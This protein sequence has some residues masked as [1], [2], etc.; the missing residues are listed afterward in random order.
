M[1]VLG[2]WS[3]AMKSPFGE[4]KFDLTFTDDPPRAVMSG[5]GDDTTEVDNVVFDGDTATFTQDVASP[6]KLHIVWT[7]EVED[8]ALSGTAKAGM[9]PAQKV[10][11][12][13]V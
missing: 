9:F 2:T 13:R 4:Q 8:D 12:T 10:A 3:I 11:G 7:V 6:M 1:S 5:N